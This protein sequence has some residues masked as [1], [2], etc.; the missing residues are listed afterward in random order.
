MAEIMIGSFSL[1][2]I[3]ALFFLYSF[4]GWCSE[5]VFATLKTGKFVNRGFLNG[6]VCPIYGVGATAVL[7]LLTPLKGQFWLVFLCAALLCSAIE[8]ITGFVLEKV[9]HRKWWDYSSRKFNL[10]GYVCPEMSLLWGGLCLIVVYAVQPALDALISKIPLTVG[11]VLLGIAAGTLIVD[12]V[13][14][15][16]QISALGKRYKEL[17]K[18]NAVLRIGSDAIGGVLSGITAKGANAAEHIKEKGSDKVA[19]LKAK[20]A[21]KSAALRKKIENSRLVRAFPR[22]RDKI[23]E[24]KQDENKK[25]EDGDKKE[26]D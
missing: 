11:Y 24:E 22:L 5:V 23:G 1:Y 15:L 18:I 14:T 7:L 20:S 12:I 6:P 4:L 16:L 10:M 26:K 2:E 21:E 8:F 25:G 9:F 17:E 13:F 19:G 3:A